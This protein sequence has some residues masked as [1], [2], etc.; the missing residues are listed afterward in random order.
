MDPLSKVWPRGGKGSSRIWGSL[1]YAF[2]WIS[3]FLLLIIQPFIQG[4]I[5]MV[6]FTGLFSLVLIASVFSVQQAG[7][8]RFIALVIVLV[9]I[10]TRWAALLSGS[11]Y[12]VASSYILASGALGLIS[13]LLFMSIFQITEVTTRTLWEG[14]SIYLLIGLA[15]ANIFAF[16]DA[17]APGSFQDSLNPGVAM[18]LPTMIYFSFVTLATLGYGDILPTTQQ[19]RGLVIIEVLMGVLYMAILISRLV[20]AWKPGEYK[21]D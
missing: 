15:W 14:I 11:S 4:T 10:V 2:L 9:A 6:I 12:L 8:F 7:R 19:T 16:I 3:F 20:G 5:G 13:L 17:V 1:R 21:K 18:T